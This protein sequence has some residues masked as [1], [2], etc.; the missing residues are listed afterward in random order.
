[1]ADAPVFEYRTDL[2]G[3]ESSLSQMEVSAGKSYAY[4]LAADL[5]DYLAAGRD[6]EA[7]S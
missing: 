1:M 7:H 4:G 3:V 5:V 6:R 2:L